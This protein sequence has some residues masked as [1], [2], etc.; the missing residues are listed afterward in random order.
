[1]FTSVHVS[2]NKDILCDDCLSDSCKQDT[3]SAG[4]KILSPKY[5]VSMTAALQQQEAITCRCHCSILQEQEARRGGD[6]ALA[7]SAAATRFCSQVLLLPSKKQPEPGSC[8][9]VWV[10]T[11]PWRPF[12]F[13]KGEG[14]ITI[15]TMY[16]VPLTHYSRVAAS[17]SKLWLKLIEKPLC[18]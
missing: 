2:K 11:C 9:C 4:D 12:S 1:M 18:R 16:N 10:V 6:E 7:T 13:L 15:G 8:C 5:H 3:T 14:S 17:F